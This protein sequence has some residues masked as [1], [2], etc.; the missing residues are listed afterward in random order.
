MPRET[1]RKI[2]TSPDL[3]HAEVVRDF[4]GSVAMTTHGSPTFSGVSGSSTVTT[5]RD[6]N[7]VAFTSAAL[8]VTSTAGS[9]TTANL[10][11]NGT[12][13]ASTT[14]GITPTATV[15][16]TQNTHTTPLNAPAYTVE[17]VGGTVTGTV[18]VDRE[19]RL[20]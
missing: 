17:A 19:Q 11:R 13:I 20:G 1:A 2:E 6:S 12:T 18:T 14:G 15:S 8:K 7:L 4:A 3:V 16:A 10:K 5:V 9:P